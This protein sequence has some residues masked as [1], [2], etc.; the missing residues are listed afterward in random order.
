MQSFAELSGGNV[1]RAQKRAAETMMC[2][3][4]I[5]AGIAERSRAKICGG[6]ELER[7]EQRRKRSDEHCFDKRRHGHDL[8][9]K[10]IAWQCSGTSGG[11]REKP[12]LE[13]NG[14]GSESGRTAAAKTSAETRRQRKAMLGSEQQRQRCGQ[15]SSGLAQDSTAKAK[16]RSAAQRQ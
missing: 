13:T 1:S 15:N 12:C 3:G 16:V 10:G 7:H 8:H 5:C 4:L 11:G 14:G 9:G 6:R 2:I